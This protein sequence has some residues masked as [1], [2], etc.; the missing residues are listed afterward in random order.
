MSEECDAADV[1]ALLDDAVA[2][3]I[4]T[5][6]RETA[7]SASTLSDRCNVSTPTVYRRLE[8]LREC[9]LVVEQTRYDPDGHHHKVYAATVDRV[10]FDVTPDG[11]DVAVARRE[12]IADG[13]ADEFTRLIEDM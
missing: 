13:L 5:E 1:A 2:R 7:M 6:T 11:L 12:R 10:A 4:L 9:G 8:R 3:T